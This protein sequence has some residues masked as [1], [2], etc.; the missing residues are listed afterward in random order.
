[1]GRLIATV[2]D[3]SGRKPDNDFL[4]ILAKKSA[5]S[6]YSVKHRIYLEPSRK[7]A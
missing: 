6:L 1:V 5:L 4:L 7:S 2:F 3:E